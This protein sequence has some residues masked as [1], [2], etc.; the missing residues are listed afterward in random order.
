VSGPVVFTVNAG[1]YSERVVVPAVSG[2]SATNTITFD[3]VDKS[4]RTVTFAG[5]SSAN[6]AVIV[7]SGCSYV[8]FENLSIIGTGS[9]YST[10]VYIAPYSTYNTVSNCIVSV[11]VYSSSYI[12]PIQ[13]SGSEASY[14]S[15]GAGIAHN[16]VTF[17]DISG[18]YFGV[19]F[20]GNTY[21]G[22]TYDCVENKIKN[23]NIDYVYYYGV[24]FYRQGQYELIGNEFPGN[25]G[26]TSA[27][28]IY[29]YYGSQGKI[30]DNLIHGGYCGIMNYYENY[31]TTSLHSQIYNNMVM[32]LKYN[33]QYGIY[34]YQAYN[35]EIYHNS[36]WIQPSNASASYAA[37]YCYSYYPLIKNNIFVNTGAGAAMYLYYYA[38]NAGDVDYNNYYSTSSYF[39]YFGNTYSNLSSLQSGNSA[40][41]QN[42]ISEVPHFTDYTDVHYSFGS[43]PLFGP[44]M[45]AVPKDID[46]ENR[47]TTTTMLGADEQEFPDHDMDLISILSPIVPAPGN[48]TVKI[49][50]VNSGSLPITPQTLNFGYSIN[51]GTWVNE[52]YSL[53]TSIPAYSQ[54]RT[55]TFTTPWYIPAAGTYDLC[56]RIS[57]QITSDPDAS[58]QIC[59]SAC[60][61]FKGNYTIDAAGGGNFTNFNDAISQLATCG[62]SGPVHFTV[63]AGTYDPFEIPEIK[64]ASAVNTIT[65]EGVEKEK[66]I[67][68]SIGGST[69]SGNESCVY[70]T[71]ADYCRLSNMTFQNVSS[72]SG[73]GLWLLNSSNYNIFKNIDILLDP[74]VAN[75]YNIGIVGSNS[76]T[77]YSSQGD[78]GHNN[79][80]TY[81]YVRGGYFNVTFYGGDANTLDHCTFTRSYYYGTYCYYATDNNIQ[82]CYYFDQRPGTT[83]SGVAYSYSMMCYYGTADT[84]I[85]NVIRN[86][87]RY[88]MMIYY[89]NY[90]A[91]TYH[92]LIA[93][94][95]VSEI[96][97]PAYQYGLYHYYGYNNHVVNN[98]IW[99]NGTYNYYSYAAIMAYYG[100]YN[101][102]KNNILISTGSTMCFSAYSSYYG[103]VDY[104]DYI[105]S[106]PATYYFSYNGTSYTYANFKNYVNTSYLGVHDQNSYYQVDPELV[107]PGDLHLI[108]G[109]LGLVGTLVSNQFDVDGDP[110]CKL[111]S[112]LG[113]DEPAWKVSASDFVNDD[114]MC[115]Y[116]PLVF[117]NTGIEDDPHNTSWYLNGNFETTNWDFVHSFND[118]GWDTV[119]LI[120]ETC[121]GV[122]SIE[123][124]IYIKAPTVAPEVEFMTSN[125]VLEVG[126]DA[127]LFDL[128]KECPTGW[129]WEITPTTALNPATGKVENTYSFINGTTNTSQNPELVFAI[130]GSYD[131]CL[132]TSNSIGSSVKVCKA[133]YLNVKFSDNMCGTYSSAPQPY[134]SLYDDGGPN[135]NYGSNKF[136]T[137]ILKPCGDDVK[138]T[139]SELNL[140]GETYLRIYDGSSNLGIPLWDPK[141]GPEGI[142]GNMSNAYFDT[143]YY[144]TNSGMVYVEF[145]SG[146][147][148]SAGFKMEW[149]AI[150]TGSYAAPVASFDVPDT[151]CIVLPLHYEN[152]SYADPLTSVY[153]WDFDGNGVIDANTEH[154]EFKTQFPGI[155][156]TYKTTLTVE[157]CGGKDTFIKEVVLINPQNAP[158]GDFSADVQYPVSNQDIV[159]F[160]GNTYFLSCV[161]EF[162]WIITPTSYYYENGTNQYS[163]HPQIVFMDTVC[164]DVTAILGNSNNA[165]KKKTIT[166]A[167]YIHPKKYC[168]PSVLTLHQ[169]MG[170]THVV[171]GDIDHTSESGIQG[172]S[173]YTND[174][175]TA[176]IMGQN[177]DVT[178][179]RI[180]N[181]NK[182]ANAVWVDY[183]N[184]GDF[185]DPGEL[186][187][188]TSSSAGTSWTGTFYVPTTASLGATTM[189]VSTNYASYAMESCGPN[190]FGEIEDYRV[191]ISPDNVAPEIT[192][193]GNNPEY[194][195]VG[196]DYTD[197]GADAID[198]IMGN[199]TNYVFNGEPLFK[200][201]S[202]VNTAILG[203]YF[204]TY[205]ACDTIGNCDE[206]KRKVIVTPD[207]SAPEITLIGGD[208]FN[209]N[210]NISFVDTFYSAWDNADGDLTSQVKITGNLNEN[211]LGT[212]S[213]TY[214]VEDSK[215]YSDT[216]TRTLIV[217]DGAAPDITIL[218]DNPEYHE[219]GTPYTDMGVTY[220]DNY[221]PNNKISYNKTGLVDVTKA[222]VYNVNYSVVDYSNNANTVT[223]KVIVWD[224]T[225]PMIYALGGDVIELEV[226]TQFF[227]PG[228]DIQ[229]NAI[230]G[231]TVTRWGSF[232]TTFPDEKPTQLGNYIIFYQVTDASGNVSEILGR[233]VKVVDTHA[234]ELVLNGSP[235]IIHQQWEPYNDALYTV[236]DLFYDETELIITTDNNV[237][238]H[239]EG[240]YH[241]CYTAE[242]P[243][244]NKTSDVCRLVRVINQKTGIYETT[245][246]GVEVYPNPSSGRFMIDLNIPGKDVSI[247][248]LNLLG[249]EV[250]SVCKDEPA[251]YQYEADLSAFAE[252]IYIIRVQTTD[253]TILK[254]VVLAK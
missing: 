219:I 165:T 35:P 161:D 241:V 51:G 136:C 237:N 31:Y 167:C 45:S 244:G 159:T 208:V 50:Y 33:Y 141:Y 243:S 118:I 93:N 177:Y 131:V 89:S 71:G 23:C 199:I 151:G 109:S 98:T 103:S 132:T 234:P 171:C 20:Y 231:F 158:Y 116:S 201:S 190:Q 202:N 67:I 209:V 163:T 17:C 207:M 185:T 99:V 139:I 126:E 145:E 14:S 192:I 226:N 115:Q 1:T 138:I 9:S 211:I 106:G 174:A 179:E 91:Q 210:V 223:R 88:G 27:Y 140:A 72:A 195:E 13:A 53:T 155:A 125:N 134:G 220:A 110:R 56:V 4:T 123:K 90:Y 120:Q 191:F 149:A 58:D 162:E 94:N 34:C 144:A 147:G 108:K 47:N 225:A 128:S 229:D 6:K 95:M 41:N 22:G 169:D 107:G 160:S 172:Y 154:G 142:Q 87:G 215:G 57:P 48:N 100:Y 204:V 52:T 24:Y 232:L 79:L 188:S 65:F 5:T 129:K 166:K 216:K 250:M 221:W 101:E 248:V 38:I 113:A 176:L 206:V 224:S 137:Y 96:Q 66:V 187:S 36:V 157:N 78:W 235:Y 83:S 246:T 252:G 148:T 49:T 7:L 30:N 82:Y 183:N 16:E 124:A 196:T 21:S 46:G 180:T 43:V 92:S 184:D 3:G 39:V 68:Y 61:G 26:A 182:V 217:V 85:G 54:P 64:G 32:D 218:G 63:K 153:T 133:G 121:S 81:I 173:N 10:G 25:W 86:A 12:I 194:V 127:Q 164:Y 203:Q 242:D 146:V 239:Y 170:I 200:S 2:A 114:S 80:F 143:V 76:K 59:Y 152:T 70:L 135:G 230:S 175:S 11:P 42:S 189:R 111:V 253:D 212:Y 198:N 28:P 228:L 168:I 213:R 236:K 247:S 55:Y 238:V 249:D 60:T 102:Y 156:A 254:R 112:F 186:V 205:T 181:F 77:S 40:H 75:S 97:D 240:L 214:Y 122:D 197:A 150:G 73:Q 29:T 222:G 119:S 8:T 105:H 69:M 178:I 74:A 130:N 15:A 18:G 117:Y 62:V 233:V 19:T 193:F 104:N 251:A 37:L 245:A 227:D 44:Y 84:I